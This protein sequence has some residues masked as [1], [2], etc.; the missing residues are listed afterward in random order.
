MILQ[1]IAELSSKDGWIHLYHQE[2]CVRVSISPH[3][4]E[5]T[6]NPRSGAKR[7]LAL[8]ILV[9]FSPGRQSAYFSH[10]TFLSNWL[11]FFFFAH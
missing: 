5:I 1:D 10:L 4:C 8:F 6:A 2:P 9:F 3:L 11:S 7:V